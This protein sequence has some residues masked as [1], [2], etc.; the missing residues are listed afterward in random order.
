VKTVPLLDL[1]KYY[2]E[3]PAMPYRRPPEPATVKDIEE[4]KAQLDTVASKFSPVGFFLAECEDM[5]SSRLGHRVILPF[6]GNATLNTPPTGPFSPRG[7]ASD[8]STVK[9]VT[10]L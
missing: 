5:W 9:L 6:G 7:L 2:I 10:Y 1:M 4:L 3:G 8:M